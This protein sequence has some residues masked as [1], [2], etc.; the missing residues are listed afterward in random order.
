MVTGKLSHD[1][2]SGSDLFAISVLMFLQF[3]GHQHDGSSSF[4]SS[5]L[6]GTSET[7]L[8]LNVTTAYAMSTSVGEKEVISKWNKRKRNCRKRF[9]KYKE[10]FFH[11]I[12]F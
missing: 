11:W 3:G 8:L 12:G 7:S 6:D 9:K 1:F 10:Q 2:L 5:Q 4:V